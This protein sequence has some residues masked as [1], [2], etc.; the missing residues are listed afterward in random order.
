MVSGL[1]VDAG[2]GEGYGA[3]IMARAGRVV[4]LELDGAAAAHAA[5]RYPDVRFL[6]AD[7]CRPPL[8]DGSAD[9]VVAL[10]VLEH[11][12][13]PDGFVASCRRVL[14]PRG[15]LVLSTPNQEASPPVANPF[16]VHEYDAAELRALLRERFEEVDVLGVRHR[17]PLA[18]LERLLREP[19][20]HRLVRVPYPQ[21]PRWLRGLLRTV[22]SWDFRVSKEV[23]SAPDL[24]AVC[25]RR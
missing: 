16:H 2:S 11:L 17:L 24:L 25:R 23:G 5:R 6:R 7:L 12:H 4:G 21:L 20:P 22:T 8:A 19:V 3:A 10:Q 9:A 13:C 15:A 1:V 14:R 18:A